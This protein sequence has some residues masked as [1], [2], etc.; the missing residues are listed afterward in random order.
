MPAGLSVEID[1]GTSLLEAAQSMGLPVAQACGSEGICA[2]CGMQI[3]E[4]GES[5]P[6]EGENERRAKERNRVPEN[7]R[8][9]C[10]IWPADDLSVTTP[11]WSEQ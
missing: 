5:L 2:R 10:Q 1:P 11:Y 3:L 9:A 6:P 4:G 8:L 7:L